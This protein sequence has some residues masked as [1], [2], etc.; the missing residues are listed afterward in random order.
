MSQKKTLA[1]LSLAALSL[2]A[3]S[4][5][6]KQRDIISDQGVLPEKSQSQNLSFEKNIQ[7]QVSKSVAA[8]QNPTYGSSQSVSSLPAQQEQPQSEFPEGVREIAQKFFKLTPRNISLKGL[9]DHSVH[10]APEPVRL[11]GENLAAVR[12]FFVEHPQAPEIEMKFYLKC[13]VAEGMFDSVRAVCAAR[14]SQK[15]LQLTGHHISPQIFGQRIARL[16]DQV[17][18]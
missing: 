16:R 4:L 7:A 2:L 10:I 9:T 18:I 17:E 6:H 5:Q 11:A 12:E 13:A 15:Y 3:I 1:V 8:P 14:A